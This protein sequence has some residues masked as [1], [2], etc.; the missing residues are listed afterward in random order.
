MI[1]AIQFLL[2]SIMQL[3]AAI[4]LLRFHLQWL[5][6]P[7]QNPIGEFVMTTTNYFVLRARRHIPS[8]RR[9]DLATLFLALVAE[10]LYLAASQLVSGYPGTGLLGILLLSAVYLLKTSI[11][12]LMG[13]V[14]AQAILSWTNPYS[15]LNSILDVITRNFLQPLRRV[16]PMIGNIDMSSMA[17]FIICQLIIL[18]PLN[19]LENMVMI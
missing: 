17:L 11:Y 15:P 8:Y 14:V 6:A 2:D 7:M 1:S 5:R 10:V 9:L 3:Y 16:I 4:L 19:M 18:W 13:A 12:L